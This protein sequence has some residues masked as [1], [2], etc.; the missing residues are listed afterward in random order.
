MTSA[1]NCVMSHAAAL[2]C[3]F[4][5]RCQ[6]SLCTLCPVHLLDACQD[7]PFPLPPV[8]PMSPHPHHLLFT[9]SHTLCNKRPLAQLGGPTH[10]PTHRPLQE[11]RCTWTARAAPKFM[12]GNVTGCMRELSVCMHSTLGTQSPKAGESQV[13]CNTCRT[14]ANQKVFCRHR[15]T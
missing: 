8:F 11:L 3:A 14:A 15:H 12:T 5:M 10:A 13:T 9:C 7:T 2:L 1:V 4:P 6:L